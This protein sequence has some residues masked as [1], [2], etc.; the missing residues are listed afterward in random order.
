MALFLSTIPRFRSQELLFDGGWLK[1]WQVFVLIG[2]E[3]CLEVSYI[4]Y[5]LM[6]RRPLVDV[7][8]YN[9]GLRPYGYILAVVQFEISKG[10]SYF[11]F[12]GCS[13]LAV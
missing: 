8:G 3:A 12:C 13:Y 11:L 9:D 1:I 2:L 4:L 5:A 7:D 6:K 10:E